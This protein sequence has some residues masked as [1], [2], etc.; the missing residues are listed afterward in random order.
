MVV[1]RRGR[2]TLPVSLFSVSTHL[3]FPFTTVLGTRRIM[4][5]CKEPKKPSA[6]LA[7]CPVLPQ[8]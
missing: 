5:K 3:V 8:L 4:R 1:K 7:T 6:C 2:G